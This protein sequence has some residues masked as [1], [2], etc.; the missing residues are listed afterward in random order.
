M[1]IHIPP[2]IKKAFLKKAKDDGAKHPKLIIN[3]YEEFGFQQAKKFDGNKDGLWAAL[4]LIRVHF[5]DML[6]KDKAKQEKLKAPL[7]AKLKSAE[8]DKAKKEKDKKRVY[9]F[10]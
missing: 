1:D 2:T 6:K 5:I 8:A 7:I 3:N 9:K 4:A 10:L